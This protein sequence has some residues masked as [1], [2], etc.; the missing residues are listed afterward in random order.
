MQ[1][2]LVDGLPHATLRMASDA[3]HF[4][5]LECPDF[6]ALT[7]AEWLASTFALD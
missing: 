3:G 4:L 2:E 7:L 1:Q 5:P 6:C